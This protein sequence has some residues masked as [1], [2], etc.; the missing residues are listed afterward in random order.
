MKTNATERFTDRVA[1]YVLYRPDYPLEILDYLHEHAGLTRTSVVA[2]IGSG[3]GIF[4]RHLLDTDC[5]V[6]AIEPNE[7]MRQ[8][9]EEMLFEYPNLIS[10]NA[11]ATATTLADH[12]IDLIV[13]AQA[14]HWF[15]NDETR[16]EFQ[17]I[18]KPGGYAVLIWN[19]RLVAADDFSRDYDQLLKSPGSDYNEVNHQ[20]LTDKDFQAFF[21][22]GKYAFVTF[23]NEQV[24]DEAGL[25]GR[26]QS[27]S[28]VPAG[29]TPEGEIFIAALKAIFHQYQ[30]DGCV[31]FLYHTE[32]YSGRV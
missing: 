20:Q 21:K 16:R 6:Y 1:N 15:N 29:N 27:S 14:F 30:Q 22:D 8:A 9:A 25:I 3:T 24:F 11:T 26:A 32:V 23:P 12:S 7:A 18:L 17:R 4:T 10:L 19:N 5:K 31:R 28:Y 2:D 13:C